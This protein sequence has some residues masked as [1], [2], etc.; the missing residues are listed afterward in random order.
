[1]SDRLNR[2]QLS[3][4]IIKAVLVMLFVIGILVVG[5]HLLSATDVYWGFHGFSRP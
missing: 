5:M 1:M 4:V 2:R 3:R